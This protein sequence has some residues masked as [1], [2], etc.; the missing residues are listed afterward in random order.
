[1]TATMKFTI[2]TL[3]IL[4]AISS[5]C[6]L[7]LRSSHWIAAIVF[8]VA[9]CL[10]FYAVKMP[11]PQRYHRISFGV[12]CF[13]GF[14][15]CVLMWFSAIDHSHYYEWCNLCHAHHYSDEVRICGVPVQTVHEEPHNPTYFDRFIVDIGK[16]CK[17]EIESDRLG[18][19]WGLMLYLRPVNNYLCC[20]TGGPDNYNQGVS[21]RI[22]QFAKENPE[23]ASALYK[24]VVNEDDFDAM[25]AFIE[26]MSQPEPEE[27]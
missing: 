13:L 26:S 8:G 10:M 24:K 14:L 16:P 20:L 4:V 18:Q 21:E 15:A 27:D 3:L 17:H 2:Q 12:R 6:A 1:M 23:E 7:I 25:F 9:G 19:A 11:A 5:V 22:Q